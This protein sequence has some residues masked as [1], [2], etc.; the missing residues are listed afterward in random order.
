MDATGVQQA[1]ISVAQMPNQSTVSVRT[2]ER[3]EEGIE[4]LPFDIHS[5]ASAA[6]GEIPSLTVLS[7]AVRMTHGPVNGLIQLD[8][9]SIDTRTRLSAE[10]CEV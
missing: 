2:Q 8:G 10:D 6:V 4:L 5:L 9:F 3:I 7:D 1:E